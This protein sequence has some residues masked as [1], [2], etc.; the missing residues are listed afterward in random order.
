M[1]PTVYDSYVRPASPGLDYKTAFSGV[2]AGQLHNVRTTLQDAQAAIP[3][4]V[5][6]PTVLVG[7]GVENDLLLGVRRLHSMVVD[8]AVVFP[9]IT[10]LSFRRSLRSL[11][12]TYPKHGLPSD[13]Q[14]ERGYQEPARVDTGDGRHPERRERPYSGH[15]LVRQRR[16]SRDC[17]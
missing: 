16:R 8:V 3:R 15:G 17:G 14:E 2:T 12:G 6:A 10:G 13:V 11:V 5:N 7:H 9:H 4:P 1:C